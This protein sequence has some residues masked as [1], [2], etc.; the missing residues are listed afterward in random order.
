MY[1]IE[2]MD[3][4]IK[5]ISHYISQLFTTKYVSPQNIY[6]EDYKILTNQYCFYFAKLLQ[7]YFPEG[8]VVYVA[9]AS[10][11]IF[12]YDENYY[13]GRGFIETYFEKAFVIDEEFIL[14]NPN[15]LY[16]IDDMDQ[17]YEY[18]LCNGLTDTYR[19]NEWHEIKKSLDSYIKNLLQDTS[20][21]RKIPQN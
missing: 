10:H 21:S 20:L 1:N 2:T 3:Y 4:L 9:Q 6:V 8:K 14:L 7:E 5:Q 18:A 19:D 16:F 13:D 17:E 12:L 11:Y 15:N